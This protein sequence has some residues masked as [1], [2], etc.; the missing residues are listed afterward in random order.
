ML[1]QLVAWVGADEFFAGTQRYFAD[2][3]DNAADL[4][5][6]LEQTSGRDL[7][8]WSRELLQTAGPNTLRPEVTVGDDGRF[9]SFAVVQSAPADHPTLRS[10][11]IAIGLYDLSL[12]GPGSA[13]GL[14]R[15]YWVELDVVGDRTEV[16][17]AVGRR[18]PA[19]VLLN[20][21]DLD[22]RAD[23]VGQRSLATARSDIGAIVEVA[24]P[25]RC[26]GRQPGTWCAVPRPARV[27][28]S[29]WSWPAS[30]METDIGV[31]ETLHA[32]VVTALTLYVDPAARDHTTAM[33][34]RARPANT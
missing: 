3:A 15:V 24:A 1:K 32:D 10:H 25:V 11:R 16:P 4:L 29:R 21:D 30:T 23:P 5:A 20:D 12:R 18:Q 14:V 33:V 34:G 17:G 22:V 28:S 7:S 6:A 9:T 31:I 27:T 2:H 26:A 13:G 19:L 8:A